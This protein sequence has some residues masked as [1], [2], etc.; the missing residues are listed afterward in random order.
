MII[1]LSIILNVC[2][3]CLKNCL[4]KVSKYPIHRFSSKNK[5]KIILK[6]ALLSGGLII[7]CVPNVD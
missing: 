6:Y 1:F 2:F 3:G 7:D 4:S 5:T